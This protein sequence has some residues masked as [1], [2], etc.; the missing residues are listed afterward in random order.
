MAK[1]LQLM[2]QVPSLVPWNSHVKKCII[3]QPNPSSSQVCGPKVQEG[4]GNQQNP[5]C[6]KSQKN[7]SLFGLKDHKISKACMHLCSSFEDNS[8]RWDSQLD[9]LFSRKLLRA[10][11]KPILCILCRRSHLIHCKEHVK[12][13]RVCVTLQKIFFTS[14]FR[15]SLFKPH[16]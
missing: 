6:E 8:V 14:K 3:L 12:R 7:I 5:T 15:Y 16:P 10:Q 2:K 9:T 13:W 1:T 11:H 4:S